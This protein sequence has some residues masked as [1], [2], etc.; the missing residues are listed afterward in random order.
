MQNGYGGC[1]RVGFLFLN[2]CS[3]SLNDI[4]LAHICV[5]LVYAES[6]CS[7]HTQCGSKGIIPSLHA[8][9]D[10]DSKKMKWVPPV[11]MLQIF[12]DFY[13]QQDVD[14][15]KELDWIEEEISHI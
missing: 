10:V 8:A 6:R 3:L 15:V 11:E 9:Y 2:I 5:S 1:N 4:F 7:W 12:K 13:L 14:F